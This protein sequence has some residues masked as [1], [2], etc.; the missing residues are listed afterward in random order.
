MGW[1]KA[2][3]N[4]CRQYEVPLTD[5][6][7]GEGARSGGSNASFVCE[8][9]EELE[10]ELEAASASVGAAD[11][12]GVW[13]GVVDGVTGSI[14]YRN[15][16]THEQCTTLPVGARMQR[17]SASAT[18]AGALFEG[19]CQDDGD[20]PETEHAIRHKQLQE[21]E[22]EKAE[23]AAL[24]AQTKCSRCTLV[25]VSPVMIRPCSH[26]QCAACAARFAKCFR[27]CSKCGV[28]ATSFAKAPEAMLSN[29]AHTVAN[30]EGMA[31]EEQQQQKLLESIEKQGKALVF[32]YGNEASPCGAEDA[33]VRRNQ[34]TFLRP[35]SKA[36]TDALKQ[37]SF[38]INPGYDGV[39]MELTSNPSGKAR[40]ELGRAMTRSFPCFITLV[41]ADKMS[42]KIRSLKIEYWTQHE[43]ARSTRFI[44]W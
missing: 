9:E 10:D 14:S 5:S 4:E 22:R 21:E 3:P 27:R 31:E 16:I 36:A 38:N 30:T 33:R 40:Y 44:Q 6:K 42:L 1:S 34:T 20:E 11:G 13:V 18:N 17:P 7:G 23:T 2:E 35:L 39:R 29:L 26:V 41:F 8:S 37:V 15:T 25:L 12:A 32:E 24:L 43:Q 28:E 19:V